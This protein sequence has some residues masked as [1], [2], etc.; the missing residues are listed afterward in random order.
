MFDYPIATLAQVG[1]FPIALYLF[2]RHEPAR[3]CSLVVLGGLFFLPEITIFSVYVVDIDKDRIIYLAAILALLVQRPAL[4]LESRPITVICTVLSGMVLLNLFTW[5]A[6]PDAIQNQGRINPPLTVRWILGQSIDDFL[7]FALPFVVGTAVFRSWLDLRTMLRTL[8]GFGLAYTC[9]ILIEVALSI[10][11]KVFQLSSFIY[12]LSPTPYRR[13]G[14]TEPIVFMREGHTVSSL[15]LLTVIAAA[16]FR[17]FD[18]K[19]KWMGIKAAR[20]WNLVGLLA[21]L[22]VGSSLMGLVSFVVIHLFSSRLV[23]AFAATL[24]LFV[25]FYPMLQVLDLFPEKPLVEI[26]ASYDADRARSFGGRFDEE[27]MVIQDLGDRL[28]VGWGDFGRIPGGVIGAPGQEE[29]LDG[30]WVI[31]LGISGL[32]GL[33]IGFLVMALPVL[34]ARRRLRQVTSAETRWL[35]VAAMLCIGVRMIDL[36]LNGWWN[37]LPVFLAGA[38]F[39]SCNDLTS[40]SRAAAEERRAAMARQPRI[41]MGHTLNNRVAIEADVS[42]RA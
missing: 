9:L 41:G 19:A 31:K 42:N 24:V 25:C 33:E 13:F 28:L 12:G 30:W 26:V 4:L 21:T 17:Q 18:A 5:L 40:A 37:S 14:L 29:G 32:V 1:F 35:V 11:F 23:S 16:A 8:V 22:K 38:L 7:R 15:M 2:G 34:R 10:P 6:N 39:A 3:A 20:W 36:L 27:N